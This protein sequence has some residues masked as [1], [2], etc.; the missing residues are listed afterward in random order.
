MDFN[1][2]AAAITGAGSGIGR[3]LSLKLADAGCNLVLSDIS[4]QGLNET[5][6]LI[7][8]Q[9]ISC[10][11][12]IL[13]VR[14]RAAIEAW[15]QAAITEFGHIDA[16]FNNAGVTVVDNVRTLDYDDFNWVMDINFWGMVYGSKAFLPH[17]LDRDAGIIVNVS[18]LFGLIAVP[19]QSAYNASKFAIRGFTESLEQEMQGSGISVFSIHPGGIKTGIARNARLNK[20]Q[21]GAGKAE[22]F[23]KA[24]E[25]GARTTPEQAAEVILKGIAK[26]KRRILIGGDAHLLDWVQ[27]LLPNRYEVALSLLFRV[28]TKKSKS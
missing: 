17:F 13:D 28:N 25:R 14:D 26:G 11:T 20:K 9:N 16:V 23:A 21:L 8:N 19:A 12:T 7:E 18:S 3:A 24:F 2:K 4:E 22:Q 10:T 27:R 15:A 1:G 6:A 5:K